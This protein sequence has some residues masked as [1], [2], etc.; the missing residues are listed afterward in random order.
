MITVF[1]PTYN[2]KKE[3]HD[4][5]NSLIKQDYNDF[6]WLVVDDGSK[7]GTKEYINKIKAEKVIKIK[8]IYKENGGKQSAYNKGVNETSGDIFLCIDSDDILKE[9]VLKQIAND[10]KKIEKNDKIAGIAYTQGYIS[11]KKEVIGSS[12][13][14][15]NLEANY[16]D[17]YH[18]YK[19]TGDKLIILKTDIAKKYLFPM[20]KGEKFVPEA[21][22][23]NRISK[24]YNFICKNNIMAYKEYLDNGYSNNYF[25]LVKRNPLG[26]RLYFKELYDLEKNIY[27]ICGYL[28]FSIYGKVKFRNTIKEHPAK[29]KMILMYFPVWIIAKIRK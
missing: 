22:V 17:I 20:I 26:N 8:Y 2:R 14:N 19:V 10:F 9:N 12:F 25:N 24:D 15:H 11:N 7:D 18:K 3:L 29:I 21:L 27:N 16:F 5:Y 28:L 13:P 23:F 6:E 1:T 4:L